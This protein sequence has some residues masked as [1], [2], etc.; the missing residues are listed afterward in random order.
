MPFIESRFDYD[1]N[2]R[3]DFPYSLDE[4]FKGKHAPGLISQIEDLIATYIKNRDHPEWADKWAQVYDQNG[5]K[6]YA[7]VIVQASSDSIGPDDDQKF[8]E[9]FDEAA[10]KI[11]VDTHVRV[12][13]F[14]DPIPRN[15]TSNYGC[16]GI[17]LR[18]I[19]STYAAQ[20]RPD[21][22]TTGPW[23]HR[24]LSILG[25]HAYSPEGWVDGVP[26]TGPPVNECFKTAW[27]EDFSRRWHDTH[28]PFLQDVTPGYDGSKLNTDPT[29]LHRWGYNQQWCNALL[30]MTARY[31]QAG[32]VYNSWNGYCEGLAAMET[33]ETGSFNVDFIH[34]LMANY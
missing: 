27:K 19:E 16:P 20:F 5:E 15:P 23:L 14:I 34:R 9:A 25:I 6:R 32:L 10:G 17:D 28:I 8:A 4:R 31:G 7:V 2:F 30:R 13:F 11:V 18:K 21:P 29:G 12:G 24:Q 1:W 3:T 26:G 33:Q 22:Q